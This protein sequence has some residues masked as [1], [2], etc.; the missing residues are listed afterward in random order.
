MPSLRRGQGSVARRSPEAHFRAAARAIW[1]ETGS[2]L[3]L[4]WVAL[5]ACGATLMAFGI[6]GD[7]SG[8][9]NDRPYLSNTL[10]E[11]TSA[12]FGVPV[13]LAL[14]Q[15]LASQESEAA[16]SRSARRMARR[17]SADL[18]SAVM[19][20]TAGGVPGT[21]EVL[22][23]LRGQRESLLP[24]GDYWRSATAPR[25]HYQPYIDAIEHSMEKVGELFSLEVE[26]RL[27]EV[28]SQWSI[29][30]TES[31]FRLLATDNDWLPGLQAQQLNSLV[32]TVTGPAL[33]QWRAKGLELQRWYRREDQEAEGTSYG[34]LDT[35]RA[36]DAWFGD[37]MNYIHSVTDLTAKT[38]QAAQAFAS[39]GPSTSSV[40]HAR[41]P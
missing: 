34:E 41:R 37:I 18:E 12:A 40:R 7:Q 39:T 31:R 5:W 9:W 14:L 10:S 27:A 26:Q 30:A 6:W 3:K 33:D 20:L 36:F 4:A 25:L 38:T 13:A 2:T 21:Q 29:L 32:E 11:V 17:V 28:S 24:N 22:Q 23:L 1:I 8:F 15:R 16:D 19:A 35:L